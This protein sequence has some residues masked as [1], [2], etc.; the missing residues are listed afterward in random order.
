VAPHKASVEIVFANGPLRSLIG[1]K[2]GLGRF[3]ELI[4]IRDG[5]W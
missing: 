5:P 3:A 4:R 1:L 2:A